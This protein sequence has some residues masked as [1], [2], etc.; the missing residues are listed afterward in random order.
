VVLISFARL[1]SAYDRIVMTGIQS[2]HQ[3]LHQVLSI[4]MHTKAHYDESLRRKSVTT[5]H[6]AMTP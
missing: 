2:L 3:R 6:I 1:A 4:V 5:D